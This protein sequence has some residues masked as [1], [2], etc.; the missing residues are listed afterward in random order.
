MSDSEV[1]EVQEADP[2]PPN[3]VRFTD[4]SKDLVDKAIRSKFIL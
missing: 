2:L 1:E 4:M 3:R